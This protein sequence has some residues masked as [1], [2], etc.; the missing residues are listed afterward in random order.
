MKKRVPARRAVAAAARSSA[1]P[2]GENY[3]VVTKDVT[4][5][6]KAGSNTIQFSNPTAGAPNLDR[7][8]V[9]W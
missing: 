9:N 7:T 2:A 8:R 3:A 4:V 5:Q 1:L 6:L